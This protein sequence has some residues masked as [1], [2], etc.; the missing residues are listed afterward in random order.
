MEE[1]GVGV[2]SLNTFVLIAIKIFS[3][4]VTSKLINM[5]LF[6]YKNICF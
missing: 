1:A 4:E 2:D 6:I 5:N 3:P